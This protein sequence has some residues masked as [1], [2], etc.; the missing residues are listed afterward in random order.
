MSTIF[1][2]TETKTNTN[3]KD[4]DNP[5]P[6]E[7]ERGQVVHYFLRKDKDRYK[8]KGQDDGSK[9][10]SPPHILITLNGGADGIQFRPLSA[11]IDNLYGS[12][13]FLIHQ[14]H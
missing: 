12:Q 6:S 8:E 9:N 14:V 7:Q 13:F 1:F 3:K 2:L 5:H 11:T 10:R 4:K